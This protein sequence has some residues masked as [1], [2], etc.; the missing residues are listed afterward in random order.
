MLRLFRSN[1][2]QLLAS[3]CASTSAL[4][5]PQEMQSVTDQYIEREKQYGAS[6]YKPLPVVIGRGKGKWFEEGFGVN[7]ILN[8]VLLILGRILYSNNTSC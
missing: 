3:R 2:V 8:L 4:R 6:N 5:E 1:T 7:F